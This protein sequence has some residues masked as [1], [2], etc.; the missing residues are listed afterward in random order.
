MIKKNLKEAEDYIHQGP[1]DPSK[2]EL[3]TKI[4]QWRAMLIGA[5]AV[6]NWANR[7]SRLAKIIAENFEQDPQRKAELLQISEICAK[8]PANPCEHFWEA[9]QCEHLLASVFRQMERYMAGWAFKPDEEWWPFYEKD[10]IKEKIINRK[11]A[12]ELVEEWRIRVYEVAP[13]KIRIEREATQGI[14]GPYIITVGG[15]KA[16]GT[17]ACNELTEVICEA[18]RVI[19][20]SEPSISFRY[21]PNASTKALREVFEC[22][23]HGLGFPSLK[24]D[25][26]NI[27]QLM[28]NFGATLEEARQ[29]VHVVCMSPGTW[30]DRGMGSR[31]AHSYIIPGKI[32][33]LVFYD[34]KDIS[35]TGLQMGPHTGDAS[36][37]ET[38]EEFQEAVRKQ[39]EYFINMGCR[40][41]VLTRKVDRKSVV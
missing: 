7:Y 2:A 32:M 20:V 27:A 36:K 5:Q 21:H 4:D 17:D 31:T 11:D 41:R 33:E 3:L 40:C 6:I 26:V 18:A 23:R 15:V 35:T 34:G 38:W 12:R 14:P 28:G 9:V 16:D 13:C 1:A 24:N 39:F 19:R 25:K 29:W 22:I 8:I 37:F 30:T 10:V